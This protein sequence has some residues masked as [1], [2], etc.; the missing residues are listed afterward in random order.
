[1]K[2]TYVKNI[3]YIKIKQNKTGFLNTQDKNW[4]KLSANSMPAGGARFVL[5]KGQTC[6]LKASWPSVSFHELRS[7][8][9]SVS[10]TGL[11]TAK[12][13]EGV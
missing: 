7:S 6:S 13:Y 9:Q 3:T 4:P 10:A 1:M 2:Y 5:Y 8:C 11:L 12:V